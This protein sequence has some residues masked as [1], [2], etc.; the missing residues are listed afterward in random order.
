MICH[1]FFFFLLQ[2]N[3]INC[4]ENPASHSDISPIYDW[5][6]D[7]PT[8]PSLQKGQGVKPA[9]FFGVLAIGSFGPKW[10]KYYWFETKEQAELGELGN[11]RF[12]QSFL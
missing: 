1:L 12:C 10:C 3:T 5:G 7:N 8:P 11:N 4:H 2:K 6:V 9:R